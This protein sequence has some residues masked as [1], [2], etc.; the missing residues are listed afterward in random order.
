MYPTAPDLTGRTE[1]HILVL[2]D[3][4]VDATGFDPRSEYAEMFWLPILG[5]STLWLMR[6]I[7]LRFDTESTGFLLEIDEVSG[8]L[9]IRS[10]GGRNNAFQR[11]M[12]RLVGFNM[13]RTIDDS[14]IEV[15]RV[16]P[17]LH[18]GQLRRLSPRL[19]SLHQRVL[20]TRGVDRSEDVRRGTEVAAT[21]IGLGDS[22]DLVEQQLVAWGL[23][24]RTAHESVNHAWANKARADIAA[25]G[26]TPTAA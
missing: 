18:G 8:S 2:D 21:L 16:M 22:P 13:G 10:Q 14:T 20:E 25:A 24:P 12:N 23:E 19:Q 17:P 6:R 3:T 7:A 26:S 4:S 9:G 11:S 1:V 5:P 15:R